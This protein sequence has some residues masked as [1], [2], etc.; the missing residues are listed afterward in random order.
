MSAKPEIVYALSDPRNP[1]LP[2]YIG[3]TKGSLRR[4]LSAHRC[5][6][7]SH[8]NTPLG[9]WINSLSES[10]LVPT[11]Y[12]LEY[13]LDGAKKR[14]E[15]WISFFRPLGTLTNRSSGDGSLGLKKVTPSKEHKAKTD[16]I[17]KDCN[18]RRMKP[19]M[20]IES[21]E[22]FKSMN[23]AIRRIGVSEQ[24]FREALENGWKARGFHWKV[25]S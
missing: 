9:D 17:F 11:I 15:Y 7:K 10:C 5:W 14:E 19:V 2:R 22:V 25:L 18:E 21:G 24:Y 16:R 20:A 1:S 23:D 12:A 8:L 3:K 6:A 13:I 4:R